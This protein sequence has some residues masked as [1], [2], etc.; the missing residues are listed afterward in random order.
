GRNVRRALGTAVWG[1]IVTAPADAAVPA[2]IRK[3]LLRGLATQPRDRFP[4]RAELRTARAQDPTVR[5]KRLALA[6]VGMAAVAG[7]A[8]GFAHL[9]AGQRA[10]CAGRPARTA[11]RRGAGQ[12]GGVERAVAST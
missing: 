7:L 2:W 10:F 9:S 1:T 5:W 12:R 6:T 3:I 4:S 8:V 11:T